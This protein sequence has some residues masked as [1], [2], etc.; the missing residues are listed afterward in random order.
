MSTEITT[1]LVKQFHDNLTMLAQ[2]TNSR[3]SDCVRNE[4]INAEDGFYD[5][6][7]AADGT[8]ITTRHADTVYANTPHARR[9]ITPIPWQWADLIDRADKVRMLGDPQN[10]YLQTAVAS[11]NRRKDDHIINAF[12]GTAYTGKTGT[13]AVTYPTAATHVV[14]VNLGG[15]N[16][17][18]TVNKL[19][20]AKRL[21][22]TLDVD[23]DR[24]ELY[25]ALD[26]QSLE[27]L[28][29]TTQV[30]SADYNSVK[31]LVQGDIDTFMGFKFK[32]SNRLLLDGSGHR[33]IPVWCKSGVM[34]ATADDKTVKID[35]LPTKNYTTQVYVGAD[36]GSARME[37]TKVI[38]IKCLVA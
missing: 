14:P 8:D 31:A 10:S 25:C 36:M 20:R 23:L 7:G 5:Q 19:I 2:Q 17:G 32:K 21:L 30:T 26:G 33:R 24:E 28:L 3:F 35:Q 27:D 13:T 38:E 37:E 16:E 34:L 4:P 15:S 11:M 12:F 22:I 1:A 29:K 9:K 18:M 6:I